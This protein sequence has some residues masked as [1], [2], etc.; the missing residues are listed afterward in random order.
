[1]SNIYKVRRNTSYK[2]DFMRQVP[3][4]GNV[5]FESE[6]AN[7]LP[8]NAEIVANRMHSLALSALSKHHKVNRGQ[9]ERATLRAMHMADLRRPGA[10]V[11]TEQVEVAGIEPT[12]SETNNDKLYR[13][14][15]RDGTELTRRFVAFASKDSAQPDFKAYF[16]LDDPLHFETHN[17]FLDGLEEF[18]FVDRSTPTTG[19]NQILQLDDVMLLRQGFNPEVE[20]AAQS[21]PD[22]M[23]GVFYSAI[24][25]QPTEYS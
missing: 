1:M 8:P 23:S 15:Q 7:T 14:A 10:L 11:L 9:L 22:N 21:S 19:I 17:H 5:R 2:S 13:I 20:G 24:R 4:L 16:V 25:K 6:R 18:S 3:E 12:E